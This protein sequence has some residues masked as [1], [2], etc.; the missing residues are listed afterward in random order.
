MSDTSAVNVVSLSLC[1]FARSKETTIP[2]KDLI[3]SVSKLLV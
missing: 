2:D 1:K 3:Y